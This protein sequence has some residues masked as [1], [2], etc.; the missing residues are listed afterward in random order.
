MRILVAT[1]LFHLDPHHCFFQF[2]SFLNCSTFTIFGSFR[3]LNFRIRFE[4]LNNVFSGSNGQENISLFWTQYLLIIDVFLEY[5]F[6]TMY[7][8]RQMEVVCQSYDPCKLM[9]RVTQRGPH[10]S[11]SHPRVRFLDV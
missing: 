10:S 3:V 7:H 1:R 9:Y 6:L 5:I 2:F 11:V 8:V 4:A